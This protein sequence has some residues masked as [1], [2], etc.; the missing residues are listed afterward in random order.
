[1]RLFKL[2]L[3]AAIAALL[4]FAAPA[5]ADTITPRTATSVAGLEA[6]GLTSFKATHLVD[7]NQAR[8]RA[9]TT[10]T[11]RATRPG[12]W[13]GIRTSNSSSNSSSNSNR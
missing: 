2:T 3:P 1:M 4:P 7:D 5:G 6:G 11:V 10:R 9:T 8:G 13:A 12:R